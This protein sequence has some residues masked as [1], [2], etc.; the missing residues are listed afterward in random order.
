MKHVILLL[1]DLVPG[2]AQRIFIDL[3]NALTTAGYK[4]SA[5]V[6]YPCQGAWSFSPETEVVYLSNTEHGPWSWVT[7]PALFFRLRKT[8]KSKHPDAV[9]STL[10]GMNLLTLLATSNRSEDYPVMIRE[11]STIQNKTNILIG[12]LKKHLYPTAS[13]IIAVSEGVSDDLEITAGLARSNLHVINNPVSIEQVKQASRAQVS[14]KWLND[15]SCP[16][17]ISVGR[18]TKAKD[19]ETLIKA[20]DLVRRKVPAKLIIVGEGPERLGLEH[21]VHSMR[22]DDTVDMPGHLDNPYALMARA[23]AFV[24]S[25]RWE[26]FVNV[27]LEALALGMPIVSTDCHSSPREILKNG[28]YG[29]LVAP[30]DTHQMA[31]S[32]QDVLTSRPQPEHQAERASDYSPEL[33]FERYCTLINKLSNTPDNTLDHR[34]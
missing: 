1:P 34:I 28:E 20:F 25:S 30:G 11:A 22:L 13:A 10:T 12:I 5:I 6:A 4:T 8:L 16:V 33:L 18:L 15:K 26:G 32:M 23:D 24:L 27:L 29:Y 9:V 7:L 17:F 31:E 14:H 3:A 2:G 21:L 19:H